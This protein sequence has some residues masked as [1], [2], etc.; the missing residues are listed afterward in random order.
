MAGSKKLYEDAVEALRHLSLAPS[1]R[2]AVAAALCSVFKT[3]NPRFDDARFR[4]AAREGSGAKAIEPEVLI[5]ILI[6]YLIAG[7]DEPDRPSIESIVE[8]ARESVVATLETEA[9]K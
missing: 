1:D 9:K 4:E 6:D 2:E 7:Y 3:D 5:R 8:V